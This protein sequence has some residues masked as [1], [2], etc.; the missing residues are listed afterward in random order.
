MSDFRQTKAV[1][2]VLLTDG[3]DA[4]SSRSGLSYSV[5]SLVSAVPKADISPDALLPGEMWK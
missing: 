1:R 5:L 2:G 3:E 4:V